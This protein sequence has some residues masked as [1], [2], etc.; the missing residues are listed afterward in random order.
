MG[1]NYFIKSILLLITCLFFETLTKA[2]VT[3]GA[4]GSYGLRLINPSYAGKAIQV[5]R[6]CDNKTLDIGFSCGALNTTQLTNFSII[7][8]PLTAVSTTSSMEYSLRKMN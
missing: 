2:Q 3:T 4:A 1:K 6:P 7:A 8:N 5:R